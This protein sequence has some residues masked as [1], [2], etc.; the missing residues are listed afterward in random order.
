MNERDDMEPRVHRKELRRWERSWDVRFLTFSTYQRQPIMVEV[1][2]DFFAAE[3]ARAR[4]AFG[5]ELYAWVVMPE[6]VHL[7][8]RASR[9]PWSVIARSIKT[10]TSK[11]A[12]AQRTQS[13]CGNDLPT[14]ADGKPRFWQHGGGFDRNVRNHT[15]FTKAIRYIHRNPVERGLVTTPE[16]WKWSSVRWWM[17]LRA[18]EIVCDPPPGDPVGWSRWKGYV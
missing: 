14:T 11:F 4:D 1:V 6:H 2:K 5:M 8:I 7:L 18:R 10:Q 17:G 16:D 13:S 15:E 12:I 3:L 9:S